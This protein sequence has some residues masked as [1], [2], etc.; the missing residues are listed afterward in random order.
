MIRRALLFSLG[1]RYLAFA[2]QLGTSM[3]MARL[4][5]P[6]EAGIYSLAAVA[7]TVGHVIRDFGVGDYLVKEREITPEK[8]RA[9][10]TVT[11]LFAWATALVFLGLAPVLAAAYG[12]PGVATVLHVLSLNFVLIPFG[13]TATALLFRQIRFDTVFWVQTTSLAVGSATT[14]GLALA[15]WSYLSP[16]VGAVASVLTTVAL[17]LW[18]NRAHVLVRPTTRG[19]RNVLR[20]GG[21]LTLARLAEELSEKSPDFIVA[22]LL[23]FH[24]GGVWGKAGT[25]LT[26]F[27]D[28]VTTAVAKVATP[29]LA[30]LDGGDSPGA[31]GAAGTNELWPA[32]ERAAQMLFLL[33]CAFFAWLL[34]CA[35]EVVAVLFGPQWTEA[36]VV[37][38]AGAVGGMLWAPCG[39]ANAV[40]TAR[41]HAREQLQVNLVYG[42][43]LAAAVGTGA[44]VSLAAAAVL[45]QGAVLARTMLTLRALRRRLGF[46]TRRLLRALAPSAAVALAAGALAAGAAWGCRALDAPA[47]LTLLCG[48]A[49]LAAAALL[50]ALASGHPLGQEVRLAWRQWRQLH[51]GG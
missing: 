30:R 8:V 47:L 43:L 26:S 11:T 7:V 3:A 10:F 45:L 24:A 27:Q 48:A 13:S 15:G 21:T 5:T 22:A 51:A 14:V 50:A 29:V 25:L 35:P 19:L 6:T 42:A 20:F 34:V 17:L 38:Q 2:L 31:T 23:G 32:F 4:L 41:G 46:G 12:E 49:A 36:V 44:S 9:A 16:A 39:L 37:V 40:L 18:V 28:F 33:Q 1:Q